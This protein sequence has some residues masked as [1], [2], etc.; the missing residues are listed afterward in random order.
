MAH[1][2]Y[3]KLKRKKGL[4]VYLFNV[5]IQTLLF[6][7][8]IVFKC[9]VIS[10][11]PKILN[12]TRA[13]I[14]GFSLDSQKLGLKTF[15]FL[16]YSASKGCFIFSEFTVQLRIGWRKQSKMVIEHALCL[17]PKFQRYSPQPAAVWEIPLVNTSNIVD[18]YYWSRNIRSSFPEWSTF[19]KVCDS[20]MFAY[21]LFFCRTANNS[22]WN[23]LVK[24]TNG[25]SVV[26]FKPKEFI[27]IWPALLTFGI[28]CT[29]CFPAERGLVNLIS[30]ILILS[31]GFYRN[32]L[33][34]SLCFS[35]ACNL[36]WVRHQWQ[37]PSCDFGNEFT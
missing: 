2:N 3:R 13:T 25:I 34:Y 7:L 32:P 14:K 33:L 21:G 27:L 15:L 8:A 12:C 22:S 23:M 10:E 11:V 36:C 31:K 37:D 9:S 28:H 29:V 17:Q 1:C 19:G 6:L 35:E 5:A 16:F 30:H 4:S 26:S 24:F 20:S 18:G